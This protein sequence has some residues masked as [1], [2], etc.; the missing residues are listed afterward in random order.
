MTT[1]NEL[2]NSAPRVIS[3]NTSSAAR[4]SNRRR[5]PVQREI[6][7]RALK[8]AGDQGLT[9]EEGFELYGMNPNTWRPRRKEL[10]R[11]GL[12][13]QDGLRETKSGRLSKV[14]KYQD[15]RNEAA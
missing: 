7:R 13:Y 12:V 8:L 9:D 5:E 1:V 4:Q 6:V 15:A 2:I 11:D 14:W 3:I 10:Q